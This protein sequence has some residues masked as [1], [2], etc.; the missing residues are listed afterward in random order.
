MRPKNPDKDAMPRKFR[1]R[2]QSK[3]RGVTDPPENSLSYIQAVA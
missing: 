1:F 2:K 3:A